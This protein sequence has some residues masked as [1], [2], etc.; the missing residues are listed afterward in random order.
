MRMGTDYTQDQ[1]TGKIRVTVLLEPSQCE[2][3]EKLKEQKGAPVSAQ[4]RIAVTRYLTSQ[5]QRA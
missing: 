4:V 2:A 5:E 1:G 3:L